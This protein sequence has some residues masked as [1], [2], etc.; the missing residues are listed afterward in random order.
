MIL[1]RLEHLSTELIGLKRPE[2]T[3]SALLIDSASK[4]QVKIYQNFWKTDSGTPKQ[5]PG[6]FSIKKPKID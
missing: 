5:T 4:P 2:V 6:V 3:E 1:R